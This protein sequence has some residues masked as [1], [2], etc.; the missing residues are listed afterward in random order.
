MYAGFG[1]RVFPVYEA[2]DLGEQG[3]VCACSEGANCGRPGKHPRTRDGVNEATTDRVTIEGWWTRYPNASIGVATGRPSNILVVDADASEG[4]PGVVNLTALSA[5][6]GGIPATPI[7]NTGGGGMHLFFVWT[8]RLPTGQDV[9]AKAID[10]RSDGG[11]AI[12]P[13]SRHAS[14]TQYEWR[15]NRMEAITV[16]D[17]LLNARGG[18]MVSEESAQ[19][20]GRKRVQPGFKLEKLESML[21]ALDPDNRDLWLQTGVIMGRLYL[22]TG[23]EQDAWSVYE[24]WAARSPKF[25]EDRAGNVARMREM[26]YERATEA[27]R[28]GGRPLSVGTIIAAAKAA[29]WSPFGDRTRIQWEEGNEGAITE[30]LVQALVEQPDN[31]FFN[32][33]GEVRDVLKTERPS[34]RA[35]ANAHAKGERPPEVLVVRRTTAPSLLVALANAAVLEASDKNGVPI[36]IGI[37]EKLAQMIL[38]QQAPRLPTLTGVAEWPMVGP[39]GDI[40]AGARGYDPATGLY[41]DIDPKL[42]IDERVTAEAGAA[43]LREEFLADFPF[44]D[45]TDEAAALGMMIAFMQRPLMKICPAFATVAPQPKSGKST[46]I[47]VASLAVH[48]FPIAS[49]ALAEEDE[50]LRKA[51][52][53]LMVAKFPAVLFDNVGRGRTVTSD[54]LAKLLTS[55]IA[56]D[57]TLGASETRKEVNSLLVTFTGNNIEFAHDM[58]SRV[59]VIRLNA[60]TADPMRRTFRHRDVKTWAAG[61]RNNV[62]SA[63]VALVR[64]GLRAP[65]LSEGNRSRFDE[66]DEWIVKAVFVATGVDIRRKLDDVD[67]DSDEDAEA[68]A[69]LELL[70]KWQSKWRKESNGMPWRTS[71]LIEAVENKIFEEPNLRILQRATGDA[72][73]WE[74]DP[75]RAIGQMLRALNGD[76]KFEPLLL[77]SRVDKHDKV[78]KW[79]I[80]GLTEAPAAPSSAGF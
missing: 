46:L 67:S 24:T 75:A 61:Q 20:R 28:T 32:V 30:A 69:A 15:N 53:S 55:E 36:A 26:F 33:M 77:T 42:Q 11:Y 54:H 64:A 8:D 40:I 31:T 47:E 52:H 19:R 3:W 45:P 34:I 59:I 6:N 2:I 50:E 21:G 14:G 62:L 16:P 78:N 13:P 60:R 74:N 63:L 22:G 17:W 44:E 10:V 12:L 9:V 58:A 39:S 79:L 4:K 51:I 65:E 57:R 48:G 1:W 71:E 76:H 80:K 35:K 70:G 66:F 18:G 25:D 72:R 29:G 43:W 37:P 56:T 73:S 23:L 27:P 7:V 49:H 41:F 5:A 68:R 38:R